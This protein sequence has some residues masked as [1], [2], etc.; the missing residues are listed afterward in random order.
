[1][2][3]VAYDCPPDPSGAMAF[4]ALVLAV[5]VWFVAAL[6]W[7]LVEPFALPRLVA[8][9]R[10]ASVVEVRVGAGLVRVAALVRRARAALVVWAGNRSALAFALICR[11]RAASARYTGLAQY[12]EWA[13]EIASIPSASAR[14]ALM[15]EIRRY[16]P[17]DRLVHRA[18]SLRGKRCAEVRAAE[19]RRRLIEG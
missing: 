19:V 9:F 6:V 11:Y 15:N 3:A 18:R 10:A 13:A 7:R 5:P 1:M 12:E 8:A 4:A 17:S 16:Y 14:A 2:F